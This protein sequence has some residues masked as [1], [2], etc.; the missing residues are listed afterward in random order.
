MTTLRATL[1]REVLQQESTSAQV[2][3]EYEQARM[4]CETNDKLQK[5]GLIADLQYKTS[6]VK[7][8]ELKNR[9]AIE[10]KRLTEFARNSIEPQLASSKS[11]SRSIGS[12]SRRS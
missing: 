7:A 5:D 1:Q 10:V 6:K 12:I 9:D 11:D 3:S 2:H 8:E 4:E